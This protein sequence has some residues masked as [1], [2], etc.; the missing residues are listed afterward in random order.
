MNDLKNGWKNIDEFAGI[1]G[2]GITSTETFIRGRSLSIAGKVRSIFVRD[3]I[4]RFVSFFFIAMNLVLYR[5]DPDILLIN[6]IFA[7]LGI[8]FTVLAFKFFRE[9]KR[10]SDPARPSRDNLSS[11]LTF[12]RRRFPYAAVIAATSYICTFVPGLLFYFILAHGYLEPFTT[13][14][15]LVFSFIGILGT[16]SGY[17]LDTRSVKHH[18]H[19]IRICLSDLNDNALAMASQHIEEKRRMDNMIT[20]LVQV[21]ILLGFLAFIFL[22]KSVLT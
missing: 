16:V 19:H 15:Y 3:F 22:F 13:E 2:I 20:V 8:V 6:A 11:Q 17:I 10:S 21:V 14:S 7:V 4:I 9:F 18:I 12:L 5:N 1:P